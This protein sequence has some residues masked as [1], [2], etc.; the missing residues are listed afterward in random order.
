[1][2]SMK[3]RLRILAGVSVAVLFLWLALRHVDGHELLN[4]LKQVDAA[5]LL[6]GLSAFCTGYACRIKRWHIMLRHDSPHLRWRDCAGPLLGSFAVN[7]VVPLRAGDVLR[8][9]AF[10]RELSSPPGVIIATL[11]VERLLDMLML[12]VL[13]GVTL[14]YF[15]LDLGQVGQA[16]AMALWMAGSTM[17][18]VLMFPGW[19]AKPVL[20]ASQAL[21]RRWPAR[22]G[23]LHAG[24]QRSLLTL[25]HVAKGQVMPILLSWSVA[26]W[27]CE[28][29][30][31]WCIAHAI[32][33]LP[34]P[35]GAWLA[36]PVATLSTLIPS[37]PGYVGTFDFFAAHAMQQVGNPTTA[38]M[39]YALLV[40]A[41]LWLPPTVIGGLYLLRRSRNPDDTTHA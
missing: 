19:A 36:L 8:A 28:G 27:A 33:T 29:I 5:W 10:R 40:H 16:G 3:H 2:T 30:L 34:V 4:A 23:H 20:T 38:S 31:F 41:L 39:A 14:R 12:L 25:Q 35:G 7:N 11:L 18:L 1:M 21:A 37:T 13:L 24:L 15:R 9:F 17:V 26:A 32:G 6:A 22:A